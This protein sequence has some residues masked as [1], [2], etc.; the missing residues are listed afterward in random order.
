MSKFKGERLV[1][2]Y[3][4]IYIFVLCPPPPPFLS[5]R[6]LRIDCLSGANI[7]SAAHERGCNSQT[8]PSPFSRSCRLPIV[9]FP[10]GF[11]TY[12]LC[13][14]PLKSPTLVKKLSLVHG[15]HPGLPRGFIKRTTSHRI[16]TDEGF[17][18]SHFIHRL[19]SRK[20]PSGHS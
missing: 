11:R 18:P 5:L 3:L 6:P 16:T 17:P 10:P 20:G 8:F 14:K 7:V 12:S 13:H 4:A 15:S 2:I 19:I 1:S 9:L